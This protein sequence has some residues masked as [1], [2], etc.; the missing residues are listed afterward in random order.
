MDREIRRVLTGLVLLASLAGAVAPLTA[1]DDAAPPEP[2]AG[3]SLEAAEAPPD[4]PERSPLSTEPGTPDELFEAALLM[5]DV[6]R[7]DLAK[8]YLDKLMEEDL[9]DEVLMR[10]RDKWGAAGFLR[11]TNVKALHESAARLL[12][13]SNAAA[14]KQA[15]DPARVARLIGDL[16]ADP[17]RQ[18]FAEAE[19]ESL[20]VA[21]IPG[22]VTVLNDAGQAARHETIMLALMRL[23]EPAVLPLIGALESPND[24]LRANVINVLGHLRSTAALPYLW[25]PAISADSGP[26]VREAAHQALARILHVRE[27]GLDGIATGGAVARLVKAAGEH[28]RNAYPWKTAE[29]GKVSLWKWDRSRETVV[30]RAYSP[31]AAS[32]IVGLRL[33]RE[34]LSLAPDRRD[35]Q[36]LYLSLALTDDIRRNGFDRELPTGPGTAHDLALSVGAEVVQNVLTEALQAARPVTAVAALKVFEQVGTRDQLALAAAR[37]STVVAALDYP[38]PRVQFAAAA[39]ILQIDPRGSFRGAPRVVEILKRA[40]TAGGRSQAIVGEIDA[41]RGAMTAGFLA[42]LGYEPNIYMSGRDVFSAAAAQSNVDLI[43]LHPNIVRWALSETLANLRA[44]SRTASIPVV[45]QGPGDLAVRMRHNL[46]TFRLVSFS[47]AAESTADFELQLQPFLAQIK[48]PPMTPE[49]RAGQRLQAAG[50]LAHIALGHRMK[51][52]DIASAEPVLIEALLEPKL[53]PS[54]LD[55]LG[56]IASRGSQQR[57]A[58][59]VTDLAADPELR[60]VAALKLAF[61]IQRF[62]LLLSKDALD[63]LHKVWEND[64]EQPAIRTA[65]GGVVGSLKPD[66]VLAGKRLKTQAIRSR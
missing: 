12:D 19:L 22:L 8:Q 50:W 54:A 38:D 21:V 31:E 24:D 63:G 33:A 58:E 39:T 48:T 52:F 59:L 15:A 6:A 55:A 23:G 60:R 28:Y 25:Y 49:Q 29:D 26:A 9:D 44:D 34:A 64:R 65:V 18:A 45:I 13:M 30:S 66:A 51:T 42:D 40:L 16:D 5:V 36:V 53:A 43:V 47:I 61:H 17:E 35:T 3:D 56:E 2:A 11:L 10:L 41:G 32:E 4:E 37:R 27:L 57:I 14:V 1:Q 20:G 46:R 7:I 62:G